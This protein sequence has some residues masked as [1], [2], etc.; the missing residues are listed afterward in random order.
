MVE[1]RHQNC[2]LIVIAR[3]A[4]PGPPF[5][6]VLFFYWDFTFPLSLSAWLLQLLSTCP[7]RV[8]L[9]ATEVDSLDDVVAG[10]PNSGVL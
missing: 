9:L 5:H 6:V 3:K 10:M 1:T 7:I 4:S 8:P 2:L